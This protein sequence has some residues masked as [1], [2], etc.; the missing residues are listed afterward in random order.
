MTIRCDCL[1]DRC[2]QHSVTDLAGNGAGSEIL[3]EMAA[4]GMR[5]S[6]PR[7]QVR[8]YSP[9]DT[10]AAL[11]PFLAYRHYAQQGQADFHWLF[12]GDDDTLFMVDAAR[13]AVAMLD[14]DMP[15]FLTGRHL[16]LLALPWDQES[17]GA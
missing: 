13:E 6:R 11:A 4:G 10:R 2:W 8:S 14:A 5:V 7:V 1:P 9:G 16:H 12:V 17:L 15:I 3:P